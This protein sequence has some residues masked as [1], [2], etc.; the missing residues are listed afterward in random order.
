MYLENVFLHGGPAAALLGISPMRA[1]KESDNWF[2]NLPVKQKAQLQ[3]LIGRVGK[4]IVMPP[5]SSL[6]EIFEE[7][8][9]R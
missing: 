4:I 2:G 9:K 7:M 1:L 3:Y 5:P 6:Q 8:V